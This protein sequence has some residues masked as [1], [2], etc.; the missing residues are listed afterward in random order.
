MPHF[1]LERVLWFYPGLN[2]IL[3]IVRFQPS[4]VSYKIEGD[5]LVEANDY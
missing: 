3:T 5:V 2:G 1:S 4:N